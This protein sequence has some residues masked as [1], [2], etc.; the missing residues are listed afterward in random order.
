MKL[1]L[2]T[3]TALT[4]VAPGASAEVLTLAEAVDRALSSTPSVQAATARMEAAAARSEQASGFRWFSLDLTESYIGTDS[5]A[6]V[7]ALQLNQE[8]FDK[9]A[10]FLSDPNQAEWLDTWSTRLEAT[11]PVY[12]GGHLS[13]RIAQAGRMANAAGLELAHTREQAAFAAVS[14]YTNLAKAREYRALLEEARATTAAHVR[15]AEQFAG[16]G[17]I[18]DAEVLKARVYLAEVDELLAQADNGS[19]LAEAALNFEI[20]HDQSAHWELAPLPPPPPAPGELLDWTAAALERRRDL[21]AAREKLEAGRLEERV[22]RAPF[23]PEV[24]VV[25]RYDLYDDGPF[26]ANGQSG[27]VVGVARINLFRGGADAAG[28][29]AARH[30]AASFASDVRRFEEGVTLEV[31]QA[32]HDLATA[33]ARQTTANASLAAAREALTVREARFRQGLDRMIDLLDAETALREAEVREL[34]AR[35]DLFLASYRLHFASGA[36]LVDLILPTE[37]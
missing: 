24:A 10:F 31:R 6:E 34:L 16:Q 12:T 33:R 13:G 30:E 36:S 5:P 37:E 27:S 35:Y 2:L 32:W 25:G 19:L 8:R 3:L 7:F 28:L 29:A 11:L 14:S 26:G 23:L 15:L 9:Q 22:A 20:G 17:L 21:G 1:L 18:L 4:V